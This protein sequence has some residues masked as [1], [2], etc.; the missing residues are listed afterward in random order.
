[1]FIKKI[2]LLS[3]FTAMFFAHSLAAQ[4]ENG[5]GFKDA[6]KGR[7]L[8]GV[9]LN[10]EQFFGKSAEKTALIKKHFNSIT[11]ENCMK[12]AALQP[13]E[14]EFN[15]TEADAF[16]KFGKENGMFI[17]GHTLL[18]HEQ[19]PAWFFQDEN[20]KNASPELL[21]KRIRT[22]INTVVGRYKGVVK[23][24][25]VVNEAV[26]S[27]GAFRKSK[28]YEIL[29]EEF[30]AFAFQCAHEADPNAQLYY[31]DYDMAAEG[32]RN[33]VVR[34]IK[35]LKEK[36]MR[37]DAVGMQT[38]ISMKYPK[39][40]DFEKSIKAFA[41][42]GVKIVISE[43]DMSV[44]PS[45]WGVK[46]ESMGEKEFNDKYN[47]YAAGL[48]DDIS[49]SWNARMESFLQL[50]LKHSDSILR[51]SAWGLSDGESWLNFIPINKR[52]DY[53]LLF[54]RNLAPKPF[55]KK[56]IEKN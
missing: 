9:A 56:F 2:L 38:H 17:V 52:T 51:V 5:R 6:A 4:S 7:F 49:A 18:W 47:P 8:T 44:L 32:K 14:G 37:I 31:N 33:T 36:G 40:E 28:F 26:E 50:F 10:T 3:A 30:I 22:H 48:P 54:D 12:P 16:V 29:G 13:K 45:A 53:G 20:G 1:M 11:P 23:G 43:W 39:I 15:F 19:I 34:I 41:N 35:A 21:K 27:D 24:W 55:L 25:D 42:A 46:R